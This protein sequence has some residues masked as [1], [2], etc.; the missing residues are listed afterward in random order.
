MKKAND[1]WQ[2]NNRQLT[3]VIQDKDKE[4]KDLSNNV[5]NQ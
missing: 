3:K 1:V 4:I 5:E 2:D